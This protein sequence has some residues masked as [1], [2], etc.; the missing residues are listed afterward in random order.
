M[1]Q[2]SSYWALIFISLT[3]LFR[4]SVWLMMCYLYSNISQTDFI[5]YTVFIT[6][7]AYFV[8]STFNDISRE[9]IIL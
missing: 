8:F 1:K 9:M 3:A 2:I 6:G 4:F 5:L 7:M